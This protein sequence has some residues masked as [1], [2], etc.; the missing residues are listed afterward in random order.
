MDINSSVV[1]VGVGE[2][3]SALGGILKKKEIKVDFWDK[4]IDLVMGQKALAEI[5]P[6]VDFL[7]FCVPSSAM[8]EAVKSVLPFLSQR[9]IIISLA[10]GIEE[11]SKDTMDKLLEKLL[12]DNQNFAVLGGPMLAE[13]LS[14]GM[15]GVAVVG[16]KNKINF[17]KL[18]GLFENTNLSLEYSGEVRS[19]ALASVLKNIYAIGLGIADGLEWGENQKGWLISKSVQE[20][21]ELMTLLGGK[22]EL[23]YSP[24]GLGDLIAT[25]YSSYSSN[26]KVGEAVAKTGEHLVSEGSKS[27]PFIL[28]SITGKESEFK[29][30]PA[31]N[32]ILLENQ[33]AKIIFGQFFQQSK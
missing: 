3:G 21:A 28:G 6:S 32:K 22:Q 7:F 13:E 2:M 26:R 15:G 11:A 31:L 27:L 20:M 14:K 12:P 17:E 23:I 1:I 10:K 19:V 8:T 4:S 16:T 30:L 9:T 29:I 25:G 5:I 33:N 18:S 24:A